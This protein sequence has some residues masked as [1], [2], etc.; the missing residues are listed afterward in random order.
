MYNMYTVVSTTIILAAVILL[1]DGIGYFLR[2][3]DKNETSKKQGEYWARGICLV[4]GGLFMLF[5]SFTFHVY[6][7]KLRAEYEHHS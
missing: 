6:F 3:F 1:S 7:T 5:A 4:A 2:G